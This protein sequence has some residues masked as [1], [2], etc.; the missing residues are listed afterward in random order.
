M[1]PKHVHLISKYAQ[2]LHLTCLI[3]LILFKWLPLALPYTV[4]LSYLLSL[5]LRHFVLLP[6]VII[7]HFRANMFT[8]ADHNYYAL[9]T[10]AGYGIGLGYAK[11]FARDNFNL[12]LVGR[13]LDRLNEAKKIVQS[14]YSVDVL[15]VD[16]DLSDRDTCVQKLVQR[17]NQERPNAKVIHLVNNAGFGSYGE[18]VKLDIDSEVNMV[19]LNIVALMK[20]CHHFGNEMIKLKSDPSHANITPR[21]TNLGS[22]SSFIPNPNGT[23]YAATK[24]FVLAFSL[25]LAQE[26]SKYGI[27]ATTV[28]PGTIATSFFERAKSTN[29]KFIKSSVKA[30][31]EELVNETYPQMMTGQLVAINSAMNN[32]VSSYSQF[33]NILCVRLNLILVST[34]FRE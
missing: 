13:S 14:N 9:I 15:L 6:Y 3:T 4:L 25:G 10:G 7:P 32:F 16:Q 34:F 20:L 11:K 26:L 18:F 28:C 23:T 17:I 22:V 33:L 8:H 24:H 30:T 1:N 27:T 31:V 2:P 12:I 19:D 21:I 29:T 5:A